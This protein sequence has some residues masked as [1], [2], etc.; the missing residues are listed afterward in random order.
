MHVQGAVGEGG[1]E[2]GMGLAPSQ[3]AIRPNFMNLAIKLPFRSCRPFFK[4]PRCNANRVWPNLKV[5]S[6]VPLSSLHNHL[7]NISNN[8]EVTSHFAQIFK[9]LCFLIV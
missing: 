3:T 8:F 2:M 6:A 7:L 4:I 5:F 9:A 1:V